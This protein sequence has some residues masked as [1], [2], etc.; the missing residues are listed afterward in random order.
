M[1]TFIEKINALFNDPE[2]RSKLVTYRWPLAIVAAIIFILLMEPQ[3]FWIGLLI[4]L[5]GEGLQVWCF[6]TLHKKKDLAAKGPYAVIRNPMYIGR[7][8]LILG[9]VAIT[10][11]LFLMVVFT[12]IYYFYMTNRVGREEAVLKEIFADSY[13]DYCNRVNR[14]L[15]AFKELEREEIR[16]FNWD[17]FFR[18]NAHLNIL[19]VLAGYWVAYIWLF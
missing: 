11:S 2:L 1:G 4:S 12:V 18:N 16:Y 19:S 5:A 13:P 10:G 6:A 8:L 17:L 3:Y 15:P 9:A 14:F 7:Y